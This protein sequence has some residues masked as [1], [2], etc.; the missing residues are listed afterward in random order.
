MQNALS[1]E[2]LEVIRMRFDAQRS[3]EAVKTA[4]LR[5]MGR[6]STEDMGKS[7]KAAASADDFEKSLAAFTGESGFMLFYEIDHSRWLPLYGIKQKAVRL[8]FGNPLIAITMI[9]H[10]INAALFAPVELLLVES[11]DG[12]G[13]TILYDLPSSLMRA[14]RQP[15]LL[16]AAQQ[17]DAKFQALVSQATGLAG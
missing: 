14:K 12:D 11:E 1:T 17:L 16:D 2:T 7:L 3:F 10:D 5:Q 8:I 15:Q 6:I 13:C 9:K 4:L